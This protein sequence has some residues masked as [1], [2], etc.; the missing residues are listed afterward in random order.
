VV[1]VNVTPDLVVE[2]DRCLDVSRDD[3]LLPANKGKNVLLGLLQGTLIR[4][5]ILRTGCLAR[6]L[7][8]GRRDTVLEDQKGGRVVELI[9]NNQVH[10]ELVTDLASSLVANMLVVEGIDLKRRETRRRVA[11]DE[12]HDVGTGLESVLAIGGEYLP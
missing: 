10:T 1:T 5:C 7:V 2:L 4:L 6:K 9:W 11:A 3:L 8:V 12:V